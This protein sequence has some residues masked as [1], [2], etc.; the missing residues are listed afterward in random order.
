[1]KQQA[2]W[3]RTVGGFYETPSPTRALGSASDI[4]ALQFPSGLI[5]LWHTENGHDPLEIV[6]SV[7]F[8][9]D[10]SPLFSMV[11]R[12]VGGQMLLQAILQILYR[13]YPRAR[14]ATSAPR[15]AS[16]ATNTKQAGN[17]SLRRTHGSIA[18]QNCFRREQLF[19]RRF[20]RQQHLGVS[21]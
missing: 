8:D 3:P 21:H 4:D 5:R 10:S 20:Q 17:H 19:F 16:S 9:L 13:R 2:K 1:M 6:R 7:V 18:A 12:N 15:F 14:I 11:N